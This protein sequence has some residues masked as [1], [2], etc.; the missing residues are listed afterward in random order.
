MF[1]KAVQNFFRDCESY[2]LKCF[3]A[4]S[5]NYLKKKYPRK[6]SWLDKH[7]FYTISQQTTARVYEI[8]KL[9]QL[10]LRLQNR[11]GTHSNISAFLDI[12]RAF[13]TIL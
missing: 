9:L 2:G 3:D 11:Y 12:M 13:D 5:T 4:A 7:L 6:N 1:I 8:P 10:H